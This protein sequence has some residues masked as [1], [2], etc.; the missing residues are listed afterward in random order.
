MTLTLY[1]KRPID[2]ESF[3]GVKI[4]VVPNQSMT[5]HEIIQRFTRKESLPIE[6]EGQYAEDLGDLEK[7][8]RQDITIRHERADEVRAATKRWAKKEAD[9]LKADKKDGGGSGE[10][11]KGATPPVQTPINT[12]P[13]GPHPGSHSS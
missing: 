6:K 7:L 9:K 5:L 12:P 10:P 13:P 11:L 3:K 1:P 2:T 8:Q 4:V